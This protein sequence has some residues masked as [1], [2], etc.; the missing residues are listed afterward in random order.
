M[1]I[2]E[3]MMEAHFVQRKNPKD[4][5]VIARAVSV[6]LYIYSVLNFEGKHLAVFLLLLYQIKT[7]TLGETIACFYSWKGSR[8]YEAW[9][10]EVCFRRIFS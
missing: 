7:R 5:T 4:F 8:R 10:E 2:F 6:S 9:R 1:A 3:K